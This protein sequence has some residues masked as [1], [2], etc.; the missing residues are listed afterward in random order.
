[1]EKDG[2]RGI[3]VCHLSFVTKGRIYGKVV[4]TKD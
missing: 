3:N 4:V 2:E 1:M